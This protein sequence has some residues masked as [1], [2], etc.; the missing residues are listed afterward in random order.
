MAFEVL[1]IIS[2]NRISQTVIIHDNHSSKSNIDI[3]VPSGSSLG[4]LL[5]LLYVNDLPNCISSTPGLFADD[6]CILVTANTSNELKYSLNYE[7]AKIDGWIVANKLTLSAAKSSTIIIKPK[8]PSP[9][10]EMNLS[11]A[12]GS[13]KVVSSAKYLGVFIDDKLKFSRAHSLFGEEILALSGIF[14]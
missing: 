14:K 6:T 10:V 1:S 5:F 7:L 9:P 8:L 2:L 4:P 12:A 11:C 3:K 13:I